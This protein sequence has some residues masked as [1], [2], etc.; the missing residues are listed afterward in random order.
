MPI[1]S[2]KVVPSNTAE[3]ERFF[4]GTPVTPSTDSVG[5]DEL[6]ADAVLTVNIKDANVT[7]PKMADANV[8]DPKLADMP[9]LSLKA[10][11]TD[12][13]GVPGN[14]LAATADTFCARRGDQLVFDPLLDGDIPATVARTSYVD[15]GDAAV[16]SAFG[17]ADTALAASILSTTDSRYVALA[18]VLN[19][20]ATYDPPSLTDGSETSITVTVTGAV[21]GDFAL[22][23]FSLSTQGIKL[24][25]EVTAADTV[26]VNL[27]NKTGG[28]LD[29]ASGTLRV[30][31]W[32]H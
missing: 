1:Q 18:N 23:S 12:T 6:K 4:R 31:V 10:R 30:R 22:A 21:L 11:A 27:N 20:S 15:A 32:K 17:A 13:D 16:T 29:L 25:A 26:T 7:T 14:L 2:F 3:W 5:P 24:A 28:T 8:T 19:G 9:A